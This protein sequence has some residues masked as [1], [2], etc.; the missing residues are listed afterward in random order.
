VGNWG[1]S[2]VASGHQAIQR[3]EYIGR[4]NQAI[5]EEA[6]EGIEEATIEG[7]KYR[8]SRS[9]EPRKALKSSERSFVLP[10]GRREGSERY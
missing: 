4:T 9:G 10:R 8:I 2:V 1:W 5:G 3:D 7:L 6:N